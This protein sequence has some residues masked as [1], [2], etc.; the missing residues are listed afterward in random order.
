MDELTLDFEKSL[1]MESK[2]VIG[3][4]IELGIDSFVKDGILKDVPIVNTIVSVLKI[5]KNIH[6]RNL[7]KQTLTFINE[8]NSNDISEEK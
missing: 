5:G 4:Y 7:L 1:F 8:F 6:D 3:D 2:D